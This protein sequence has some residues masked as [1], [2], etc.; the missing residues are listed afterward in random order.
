MPLDVFGWSHASNAGTEFYRLK[1]PLRALTEAY[2]WKTRVSEYWDVFWR[3]CKTVIGQRV[4]NKAPSSLWYHHKGF[5][6]YEWDDDLLAVPSSNPAFGVYGDGE[7]QARVRENLA[8]ADRVICSTPALAEIAST[9]NDD[10]RLVPNMLP[11]RFLELPV[12]PK[13]KHPGSG[14]KVTIGWAGSATH[15]EDWREAAHY[16]G[17]FVERNSDR[18]E[19]HAIGGFDA[20]WVTRKT[21]WIDGV[22][23]YVQALDFDIGLA[24]L[25]PNIFNQSKSAIKVLEYWARDILPICSDVGPYSD[26]ITDGVN[27][28]LVKRP[29]EWTHALREAGGDPDL[30]AECVM[31]G[32]AK[33]EKMILEKN[34]WIWKEALSS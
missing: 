26:I 33:L 10:V 19:F 18:V 28:L 15:N 4:T 11:Q 16:V 34:A 23:G 5:K 2:G 8:A 25:R 13:E 21:E 20:P 24:P 3:D 22:D 12:S 17:R 27:G 29:H 32:R 30:R 6:V 1:E 14:N 9:W 7:A 31:N